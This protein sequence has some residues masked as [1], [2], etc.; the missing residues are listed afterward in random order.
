VGYSRDLG[1]V[2]PGALSF[3]ASAVWGDTPDTG[4]NASPDAAE[5]DLL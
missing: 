5:F 4:P 2:G 1:Q 3:F